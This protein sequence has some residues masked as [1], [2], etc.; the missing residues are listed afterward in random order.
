MSFDIGRA[1]IM[2]CFVGAAVIVALIVAADWKR[3]SYAKHCTEVLG[4]IPV[5]SEGAGVM[6]CMRSEPNGCA[7][8]A[9][10]YGEGKP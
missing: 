9:K 3:V 2:A 1:A 4:G 10:V 8:V 5:R 7:R 6:V